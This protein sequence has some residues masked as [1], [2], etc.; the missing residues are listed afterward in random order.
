[1]A[2]RYSN[3]ICAAFFKQRIAPGHG[4]DFVRL[5]NLMGQIFLRKNVFISN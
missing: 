3:K 1:M 4:Y 5:G 2:F